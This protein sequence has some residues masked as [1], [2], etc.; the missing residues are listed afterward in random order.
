MLKI[1]FCSQDY[2]NKITDKDLPF[3]YCLAHCLIFAH[4]CCSKSLR[5]GVKHESGCHIN[6]GNID[7]CLANI[8]I[9]KNFFNNISYYSIFASLLSDCIKVALIRN[10]VDFEGAENAEKMENFNIALLG[11]NEKEGSFLQKLLNRNLKEEEENAPFWQQCI[12]MVK[13]EKNQIEDESKK[14]MNTRRTIFSDCPEK[15]FIEYLEKSMNKHKKGFLTFQAKIKA[16]EEIANRKFLVENDKENPAES[17]QL[18]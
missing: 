13:D 18:I 14:I 8:E 12:N 17:C 1:I 10:F 15:K 2:I 16:E 11:E 6:N 7:S 5:G 3:L 4:V 9:E